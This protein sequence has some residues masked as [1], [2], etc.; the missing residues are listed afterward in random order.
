MKLDCLLV[1][2]TSPNICGP[3]QKSLMS[4]LST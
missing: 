2:R 4:S 1:V 3:C